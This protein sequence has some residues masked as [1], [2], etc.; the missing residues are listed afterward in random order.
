MSTSFETFYEKAT[1]YFMTFWT[2]PTDSYITNDE[3]DRTSVISSTILD[4][5]IK[6]GDEIISNKLKYNS[7]LRDLWNTTPME[8]IIQKTTFN[9]K[10]TNENGLKGYIWYPNL[11]LSIQGKDANYAMKEI[12]NMVKV[13]NY[14]I[15]I[16]IK[17]QTGEIIKFKYNM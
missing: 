2:P 17:L 6:N 1:E 7:I 8:K 12:L 3:L 11:Q 13:N 15:Q 9:Y 4:C 5:N 16:T 14:S 10:L